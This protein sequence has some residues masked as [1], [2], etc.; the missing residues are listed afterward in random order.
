M[1]PLVGT[2]V[3]RRCTRYALVVAGTPRVLRLTPSLR[4]KSLGSWRFCEE[5]EDFS[6]AVE[7][8]ICSP[9]LT[10]W[11]MAVANHAPDSC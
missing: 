1:E 8:Q 3:V 4:E 10:R 6:R 11:E 5:R 7:K 9:Q 2:I